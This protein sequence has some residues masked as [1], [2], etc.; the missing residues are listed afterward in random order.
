M[1]RWPIRLNT[2]DDDA[3]RQGDVSMMGV[4]AE[5]ERAMIRESLAERK[6]NESCG[7]SWVFAPHSWALDPFCSLSSQLAGIDRH[8]PR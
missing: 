4:F 6:G 5:F 7:F 3:G 2:S 8:W 1:R